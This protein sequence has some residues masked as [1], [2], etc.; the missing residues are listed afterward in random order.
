MK[1]FHI[2]LCEYVSL[3][4]LDL[5]FDDNISWSY[6]EGIQRFW[7]GAERGVAIVCLVKE[8]GGGKSEVNALGKEPADRG[9]EENDAG[10]LAVGEASEVML[11]A[12]SRYENVCLCIKER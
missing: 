12:E 11:C 6:G 1:N 9:I 8:I 2:E 4:Y 7:E 5:H 3:L 10:G